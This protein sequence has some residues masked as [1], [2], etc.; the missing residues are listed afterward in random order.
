MP[1]S[2]AALEQTRKLMEKSQATADS[3]RQDAD[4]IKRLPIIRRYAD[5]PA[6]LLVRP[7]HERHRQTIPANTLFDPGRA[8]LTDAGREKL[9]ELASWFEG[10]KV[11][12][13]DV[14]V[15]AWADP[16]VTPNSVA[17]QTLTQK[18]SEVVCEYLRETQKIHKISM[19]RWRNVKP[20]GCGL[21]AP[22]VPAEPNAPAGRVEVNVFIPQ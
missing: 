14:V 17:A 21:D 22:L 11:K 9:N 16:R 13:S 8:I 2:S 7:T 1:R 19:M 20:I 3:M 6:A 18:Q 15:A 4:A 10:L 12:G 5:D